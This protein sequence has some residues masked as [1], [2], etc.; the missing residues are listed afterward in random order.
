MPADKLPPRNRRFV[1]IGA[2]FWRLDACSVGT[3]F[4][5]VRFPDGGQLLLHLVQS[6]SDS[7]FFGDWKLR[8]NLSLLLF[9][10]IQICK[11]LILSHPRNRLRNSAHLLSRP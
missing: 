10:P 2:L 8:V 11:S 1:N 7:H 4:D 9:A 3:S 6:R 5:F